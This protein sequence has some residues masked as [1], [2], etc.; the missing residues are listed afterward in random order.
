MTPYWRLAAA[1]YKLVPAKWM[2]KWAHDYLRESGGVVAYPGSH[3]FTIMATAPIDV[4]CGVADSD[5]AV[6]RMG[7]APGDTMC[8][9]ITGRRAGL[10]VYREPRYRGPCRVH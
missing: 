2:R 7:M 10:Y 6:E 4:E 9:T 8:V 3:H 1:V 5:G